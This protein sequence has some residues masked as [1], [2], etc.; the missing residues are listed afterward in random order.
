MQWQNASIYNNSS[1][2]VDSITLHIVVKGKR[3]TEGSLQLQTNAKCKVRGHQ[4]GLRGDV[5]QVWLLEPRPACCLGP[6]PLE[7]HADY[8]HLCGAELTQA[9]LR[10]A[11]CTPRSHSNG[12]INGQ[13]P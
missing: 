3:L 4:L 8:R 10:F 6:L 2:S 12:I 1:L 7:T 5:A 9:A 13:A 11:H